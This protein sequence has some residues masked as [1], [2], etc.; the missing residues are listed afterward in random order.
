MISVRF[1]ASAGSKTVG[2]RL[3]TD[4]PVISAPNSSADE[5]RPDRRVAPEQRDRDAEEPELVDAG[6][7]WW[8][9]GTASRARRARP[10]SP[11][12]APQTAITRM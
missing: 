2:S 12:N 5:Q 1:E 8:R 10:A 4:V 9:S 3:R 11:A 7:R 6:C